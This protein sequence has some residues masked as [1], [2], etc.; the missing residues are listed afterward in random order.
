MK[1]TTKIIGFLLLF[2]GVII[3]F[4]ALYSSYNIFTAK[5]EVPEIFTIPET[6]V[7]ESGGEVS[8]ATSMEDIQSQMEETMK[9]QI[10][11]MF[12]SDFIPRLMNLISWSIFATILIFGGTHVSGI[13][14]KLIKN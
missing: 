13:G 1:S 12:P 6:V 3:I 10:G 8:V 14:I 7:E 2:I 11:E 4:Y 5:T 9:E